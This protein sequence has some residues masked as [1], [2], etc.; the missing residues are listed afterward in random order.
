MIKKSLF[1]F[2]FISLI[3]TSWHSLHSQEENDIYEN[4]SS[5]WSHVRYGGGFGLSFG[6]R[7]F[8]ASLSPSAI[9]EFN[10]QFAL[11]VALTGSYA[12]ERDI[13]ESWVYGGSLISLFN[14]IREIQ[15]SAEF[16]ELS[17]N[18]DWDFLNYPD[19]NYWYPALFFGAG[20]HAD[21]FTFGIRYDVLYD[22]DKSIYNNVWMPFVRIYF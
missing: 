3:T 7:F 13:Y 8:G 2:L 20:Y 14:P 16:E 4:R 17:V 15:L 11:G 12:S 21:N 22:K 6:N 1:I 19:Q 10:D 5:F 18:R 9:Y